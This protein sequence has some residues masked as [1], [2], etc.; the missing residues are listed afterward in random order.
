MAS[1]SVADQLEDAIQSMI[2][3]PDS[4]VP[5]A[6]LPKLDLPKLDPL[7]GEVL[8]SAAE[9]RVLPA[10]GVRAALKLDLLRPTDAAR[11]AARDGQRRKATEWSQARRDT[12]THDIL[13]T[14]FGSAGTILFSA[15][16]S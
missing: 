5:K 7:L 9:L 12:S 13:P 4:G 16:I 1:I 2:A 15:E 10:T 6:D 14:L 8:G 3:D 11:I